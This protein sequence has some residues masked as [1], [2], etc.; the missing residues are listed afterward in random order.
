MRLVWLLALFSAAVVAE[1]PDPQRQQA[2]INL[3]KHDCGSCHG[4]PPKGGLGPSLMPGALANKTDT[5]LVEVIQNG[6]AGTAMPPWQ[7]FLSL[8][9]TAWLVEQLRQEGWK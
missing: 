5:F 9:E 2:L 4:L 3:L 1:Q 7:Q 8:E 6:R